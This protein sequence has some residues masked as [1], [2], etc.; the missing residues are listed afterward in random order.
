MFL[1]R[2]LKIC[3]AGRAQRVVYAQFAFFLL[4]CGLFASIWATL[5]PQIVDQPAYRVQPQNIRVWNP[6][7]WIP[8]SFVNDALE[9][10][11]PEARN[12]PM[13]SID[14]KLVKN[15]ALAFSNSPWVEKVVSVVVSYPAFVDVVLQFKEPIAKVDDSENG[16]TPFLDA[17]DEL[18]PDDDFVKTIR[19]EYSLEAP[20]DEKEQNAY[21]RIVDAFGSRLD[22]EYFKEHPETL[23]ELPTIRTYG[24]R[25]EYVEK[26]AAL[27]KFLK[28]ENVEKSFAIDKVHAFKALGQSEP[29]FYITTKEGQTVKWGRFDAPEPKEPALEYSGANAKLDNQARKNA[30]YAFQRKKFL[31]WN[32]RGVQE[33]SLDL[34]G[35]NDSEKEKQ[36]SNQEQGAEEKKEGNENP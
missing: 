35:E 3:F 21:L 20:D 34:S 6:P 11:P 1:L 17:L 36:I 15:L 29:T 27:I 4:L 7:P 14:A 32:K 26:A 13:I 25:P 2:A 9:D 16:L 28:D 24:P 30:V 8:D 10:L 18:F 23:D 31:E 12:K 19:F 33:K 5:K 22:P